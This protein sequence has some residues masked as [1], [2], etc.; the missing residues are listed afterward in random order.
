MRGVFSAFYRGGAKVVQ[1]T[2]DF[3]K[4][5][6]T[7]PNCEPAPETM[8]YGQ[9]VVWRAYH[10]D[11]AERRQDDAWVAPYAAYALATVATW[12]AVTCFTKSP[13]FGAAALSVLGNMPEIPFLGL[14]CDRSVARHEAQA[15]HIEGQMEKVT[16]EEDVVFSA[17]ARNGAKD[18]AARV[19]R[20]RPRLHL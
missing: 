13:H 3:V 12:L 4:V 16:A 15:Q 5:D 6:M 19:M 8:S 2:W 14:R 17:R 11:M 20:E 10:Q 1:A 9:C 18:L 7:R